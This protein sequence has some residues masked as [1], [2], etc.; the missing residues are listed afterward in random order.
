MSSETRATPATL[1]VFTLGPEADSRRRPVLPR[2]LRPVERVLRTHCLDRILGAGRACGM[3]L[4]VASDSRLDLPADVECRRQHG[5]GF[6]ARLRSALESVEP[7]RPDRPLVLVGADLPGFSS[8]HLDAAL[9]RLHRDPESV[10]LGPSPDGGIY[11]LATGRP[12]E[13]LLE[14][15]D[16]CRPSTRAQLSELLAAAGRRVTLLPLLADL[17][18]PADLTRLLAL[19]GSAAVDRRLVERLLTALRQACRALAPPVDRRWVHAL[20]RVHPRRGPPA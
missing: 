17:D 13:G 7:P 12:L 8:D 4:V 10:V 5:R 16:W 18:R 1:L 14:R 19:A 15:V 6:A 9:A 3:D 11:L 2:R 20:V